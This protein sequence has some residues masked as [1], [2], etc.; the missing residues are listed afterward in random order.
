MKS[1]LEQQRSLQQ[2]LARLNSTQGSSQQQNALLQYG[3]ALANLKQREAIEQLGGFTTGMYQQTPHASQTV[4]GQQADQPASV[5]D[6][7]SV[8]AMSLQS[9]TGRNG[10][11]G[12]TGQRQG[13]T[14]AGQ[15]QS[16]QNSSYMIPQQW[17]S[18]SDTSHQNYQVQQS[19]AQIQGRQQQQPQQFIQ[20]PQ[21]YSPDY[22]QQQQQRLGQG[23]YQQPQ[24]NPQN[25]YGNFRYN[26]PR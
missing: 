21:Q 25:S 20:Q 13:P 17:S 15:Q 6:L 7:L 12:N 16:L 11:Y 5:R 14:I 23:Q 19:Y 26:P 24:W 2:T 22:Q 8:Y 1:K 10:E 9:A 18:F 3:S 4:S